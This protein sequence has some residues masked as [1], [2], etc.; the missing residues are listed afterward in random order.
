[1][2]VVN[3]SLLAYLRTLPCAFCG[4]APPSQVHHVHCR[5]IGGGSRLDVWLN[6]EKL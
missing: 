4:A 6:G 1:M 2:R 3:E 5:G